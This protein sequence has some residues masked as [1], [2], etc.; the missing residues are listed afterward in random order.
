MR[1]SGPEVSGSQVTSL[2]R[3]WR[4]GD[5]GALENLVPL[6]YAEL[7]RIADRE[8]RNERPEHT[9]RPTDLVSEAYLKLSESTPPQLHDRAHFFG[10]AVRYMRQILVDH[11]RRRAAE[12]RGA[13][14]QR[15]TL[16]DSL[17]IDA[18]DELLAL[19]DALRALAE[20]DERKAQVVELHYLGGLT[21]EEIAQVLEVHVNTVARDLRFAASW[22]GRHLSTA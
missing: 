4:A 20:H 17:A 14:V 1:Y 10:I 2:L 6:V 19:D 8:M 7:R 16:D 5:V 21:H 15:V 18:G 9:F 22:L 11:A 13:N 3:A 12:K